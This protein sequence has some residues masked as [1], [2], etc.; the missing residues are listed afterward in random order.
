MTTENDVN[1]ALDNLNSDYN[2]HFEHA[3]YSM[4]AF[5]II[6]LISIS[7]FVIGLGIFVKYVLESRATIRRMSLSSQYSVQAGR[8]PNGGHDKGGLPTV[9][10]GVMLIPA[11]EVDMV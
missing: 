5:V 10:S 2:E 11:G 9:P 3:E 7:I 6:A 1:S 8:S 4:V